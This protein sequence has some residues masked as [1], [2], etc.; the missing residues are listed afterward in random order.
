MVEPSHRIVKSRLKELV[1]AVELFIENFDKEMATESSH[2]R[3]ERIGKL[4]TALE[5]VK[6]CAARYGLGRKFKSEK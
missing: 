2:G 6:D 4:V 1:K 5:F 3:G